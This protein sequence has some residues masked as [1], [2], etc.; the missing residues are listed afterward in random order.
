MKLNEAQLFDK[1][2]STLSGFKKDFETLKKANEEFNAERVR[3]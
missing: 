3:E 1:I 2:N